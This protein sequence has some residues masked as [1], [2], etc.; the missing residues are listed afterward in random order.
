[1]ISLA[2]SSLE[3]ESFRLPSTKWGARAVWTHIGA[4]PRER[5][6]GSPAAAFRLLVDRRGPAG[7]PGGR[8][9]GNPPPQTPLVVARHT[10]TKGCVD[11][12]Q[13]RSLFSP[14]TRRRAV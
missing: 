12:G 6:S 11:S 5:G 3:S 1:M 4:L 2:R 9:A 14:E 10:N 13:C 8:A 7:H